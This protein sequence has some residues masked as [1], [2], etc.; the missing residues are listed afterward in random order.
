MYDDT[1][2][3]LCTLTDDTNKKVFFRS[4]GGGGVNPLNQITFSLKKSIDE[5]THNINKVW[6][7]SGP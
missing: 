1:E 2:K 3:K 6:E 4:N 7:V 5:K